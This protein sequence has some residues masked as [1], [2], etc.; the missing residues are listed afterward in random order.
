M[1]G[2]L[3]LVAGIMQASE[4]QATAE[5]DGREL[6]ASTGEGSSYRHIA[7]LGQR[8]CGYLHLAEHMC[9]EYF[10]IARLRQTA[11]PF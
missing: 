11:T 4:A 10:T 7:N 3:L 6:Q 5:Q 9:A 1:N 8:S 2:L